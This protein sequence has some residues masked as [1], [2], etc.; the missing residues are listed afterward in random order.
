MLNQGHGASQSQ[1]GEFQRL[2]RSEAR[3]VPNSVN[4][5]IKTSL[6]RKDIQRYDERGQTTGGQWET[7]CGDMGAKGAGT[8]QLCEGRREK[9]GILIYPGC[10]NK[11]PQTYGWL[12][13][14]AVLS[15]L[16]MS[17]SLRPHGL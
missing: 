12:M 10:S 15:C 9:C 16:V 13:C 5:T 2:Q 8:L 7:G 1:E 4:L 11:A 3:K 14:C 17:N 6:W